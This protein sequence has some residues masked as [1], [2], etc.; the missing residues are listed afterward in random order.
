[1][2]RAALAIGCWF[3]ASVTG[4][5]KAIVCFLMLLFVFRIVHNKVVKRKGRREDRNIE[6][7][8]EPYFTNAFKKI[9]YM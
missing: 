7:P 5:W 1:V 3:G 2:R 4:V 9:F 6:K 8:L